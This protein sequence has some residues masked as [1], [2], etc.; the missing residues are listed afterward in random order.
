MKQPKFLEQLKKPIHGWLPEKHN[1]ASYQVDPKGVV[2]QGLILS[3]IGMGISEIFL[4]AAFLLGLYN[5]QTVFFTSQAVILGIDVFALAL[6]YWLGRRFE[7]RR[8]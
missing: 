5:N 3:I 6:V 8:C 4:G 1:M 2:K 7:K